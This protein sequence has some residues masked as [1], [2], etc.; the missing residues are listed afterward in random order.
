MQHGDLD[1]IKVLK[2]QRNSKSDLKKPNFK[3][4]LKSVLLV[5]PILHTGQ[6]GWMCPRASLVHWTCPVPLSDSRDVYR[7]C[8][9]LDQTSL[10]NNMTIGI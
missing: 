5:R 1:K 9:V 10:V 3:S 7:A 2:T 4:V 6:T 8:P